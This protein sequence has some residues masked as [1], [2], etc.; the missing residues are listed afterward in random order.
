MNG[1]AVDCRGVKSA[2]KEG[3]VKAADYPTFVRG[4]K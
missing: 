1:F 4:N 3:F 2:K